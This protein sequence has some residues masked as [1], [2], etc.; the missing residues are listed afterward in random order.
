MREKINLNHGWRVLVN[1]PAPPVAKTKAG[2]YLSAKTERLK[3]GPGAYH[4]IDVH[5]HWNTTTEL[6]SEPWQ[7]VDLP[8]DYI[9]AQMPV[10]DETC[11]LGYFK[12]Y[13]A[14]YRRHFKLS[15]DD[16]SKRLVVYFE[17]ITGISDIYLNGCFLKHNEGGYISFEVDIT[18]LARFDQ[19]NVLAV[20][21]NP[22]SY[23]TWW[24]EGGGIYR[25]VWLVKTDM[26]A[27]DLWG[28]FL[29]VRKLQD[30]LWQVPVEVEI[31]NDGYQDEAVQVEC[32]LRD[33]DGQSV[34]VLSMNGVA[35]SRDIVKLSA[36]TTIRD[37]QLWDIDSPKQYTA[38][39]TVRKN[40]NGT[41][42]DCDSVEQR[43]GFR[44]AVFTADKGF[45]LN[46][47]NVKIKG[48]CGH[49]DM[50]LVGKAVSDNLCR[51]KA[52]LYKEM[53]AN[54]F[55]T[56]H[57]PHQAA[58]MD[59][60]DELGLLVMDETRRFESNPDAIAQMEMLVKRD[61]NRPSVILWST[62]NEEG[63]YFS[64]PQ[65]IRIQ[66]ALAHAVRKLDP[67]R[68]ISAAIDHPVQA[69][70]IDELDAFGINYNLDKYDKAHADFPHTPI[71][72]SENCAVG[73]TRG[74]YYGDSPDTGRLDARDRNPG[75]G[76]FASGREETWKFIMARPWIAG[77]FQWDAVEHRGEAVWP[78]LCSVSGAIDL[79]LQRKDAFYQNQSHWLDKPMIHLLPHWN[80]NGLE[81]MP[82]TVWIYTNCEEVEL[83]LNGESLGKKA[84]TP[85]THLEYPV[86]YRPGKLEAVGYNNGKIATRDIQQ[87]TGPAIALKLT[88]ANS[89]VSF[90]GEDIA[91]FT[92]TAVDADCREVPDAMPL[93]HFDGT[94]D[95]HIVGTGSDNTDH[96][97]V[98][99]LSRKMYAGKIS[100]AVKLGSKPDGSFTLFARTDGLSSAYF[101]IR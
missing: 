51:Y 17:G 82:I 61:R 86:E 62:G 38:I 41:W 34:A 39:V 10:Q 16:Q 55:R 45:F 13:P 19:E 78:R 65:G 50:G 68:P 69:M 7:T 100:I 57:Y 99:C 72:S 58:F 30:T 2:M 20:Y 87:T 95:G 40:V 26:V 73:S 66:K 64:I 94:G 42:T 27:V 29:P 77:G 46:G 47:R 67:T 6:S 70:I 15:P 4:H 24:Y 56:S 88:L 44:E 90:N 8:H 89:P 43:F 31:R 92:C 11:A 101:D 59:A 74:W 12:S 76:T 25:N 97:P 63:T 28:V 81:G 71:F 35:K 37:P 49:L 85:N 53:G 23:E 21:V 96:V 91:L 5:E 84:V 48:V 79:F 36:G 33:P 83:F 22:D 60:C 1:P 14:W 93:V 54:A 75:S 3:W 9:I 32:D 98:P 52:Q 80:H 18:D